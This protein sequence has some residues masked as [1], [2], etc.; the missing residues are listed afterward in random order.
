MRRKLGPGIRVALALAGALAIS[1]LSAT[2]PHAQAASPAGRTAVDNRYLS[3]SEMAF[4]RDGRLLYVVCEH[5]DQLL[6][7]NAREGRVLRRIRVGHVPRTVAVSLDGRQVFVTNSWDDTVSVIDAATIDAPSINAPTIDAASRTIATGFEPYG[8]VVDRTGKTLYVANRIGNDVSVIDI[9]TGVERKRLMAGHGASYLAISADGSRVYCTHVYPRIGAQRTVPQSEITVIDTARENV[10]ERIPLEGVAGMFHVAVS[11]DGRLGVIAQ[12]RPKNL[13]PLA[14][15]EHGW[16]IGHSLTVF[17]AD[18]GGTI[19]VPL[20]ELEHYYSLQYG[21]AIAPDK[22]RIFVTASGS[23]LVTVIDTKRLLAFAHSRRKPFVND[24]S[25]SANYVIARIAVGKN[26]RGV[27]MSPDGKR[28]YVANRMDDTLS[29]ID[30]VTDKSVATIDLGGSK[31]ISAWRRGEQIFT[32]SRF[33]FQGQFSCA[34]CHIDSTF[35]GLTWDLEPDGFGKDI[36]DNRLIE[37]L[38]GTEPF[39]WNGGNPSMAQECGPR[40]E[41]YFYRSQS[42]SPTE[43]ADLVG[44]IYSLPP[45]PNRFRLPDGQ[46]T[47]AQERGKDIFE[48]TVNKFGKT[49]PEANQCGYCH[50]GPKHT[51]QKSFDVGTGKWTDRSPVFDTPQLANIA[52][53][54]PYLHDESARSLEEIWTVLNPRDQHGVTSDLSKDELNDL[55]EYLRTL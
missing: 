12:M 11:A 9:A 30:T 32:T 54:A 47:A 34:N 50:S 45:R 20:D 5:S 41:M 48:R 17:G 14:H 19:E 1:F 26:P 44:Y 18:A 43:L 21:V 46:L 27:A 10:V 23:D 24:L 3:P 13:V 7:L 49:I 42:Y 36:V 55:I 6:V 40:T 16:V 39:K 2:L 29:E 28:L 37:D 22:S 53:T 25:A 15:V 38:S 8:L 33:A 31:S 51:S 4:S 52:L 35:D